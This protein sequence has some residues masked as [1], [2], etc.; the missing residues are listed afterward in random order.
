MTYKNLIAEV[1]SAHADQ[2]LKAEKNSQDYTD[3][4]PN[5]AEL[6]SLLTLAGQVHAALK[7]VTLPKTFKEQLQ[8]DLLAAAHLRQAERVQVTDRHI[9]PSSPILTIAVTLLSTLLIGLF[10]IYKRH[11]PSDLSQSRPIP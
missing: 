4:F 6:P 9:L 5:Q 1:L 11:P 2:L 10:F 3:L 7:P 8:R